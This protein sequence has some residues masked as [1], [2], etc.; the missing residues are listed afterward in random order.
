MTHT[1]CFPHDGC[2]GCTFHEAW[3]DDKTPCCDTVWKKSWHYSDAFPNKDDKFCKWCT[4][5]FW[6]KYVEAG[7]PDRAPPPP[8]P[9]GSKRK[10][11]IEKGLAGGRAPK[12]PPGTWIAKDKGEQSASASRS[13]RPESRSL[14]SNESFSLVH[15][16]SQTDVMNK[17]YKMDEKMKGLIKKV[18]T[19]SSQLDAL[20]LMVNSV[21]LHV[22]RPPEGPAPSQDAAAPKEEPLN[23]IC[24]KR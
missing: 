21:L 16:Q 17:L 18:D 14:T 6:N 15:D 10:A 23:E 3:C 11:S 4:M 12:S 13:S 9:S 20:T 1:Y 5:E 22:Q 19:M 7:K 24:D 2:K 8:S